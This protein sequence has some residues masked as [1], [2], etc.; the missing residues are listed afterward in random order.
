VAAER[1]YDPDGT[2]PLSADARATAGVLRPLS[3]AAFHLRGAEGTARPAWCHYIVHEVL[4]APRSGVDVGGL[5]LYPVLDYPGWLND[6]TCET[7][8]LGIPDQDGQRQFYEPLLAELISS[9]AY[10]RTHD[11]DHNL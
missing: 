8:L 9:A 11:A 5:C 10:L 2:Q 3:A 7:G 4:A 6:R 1:K